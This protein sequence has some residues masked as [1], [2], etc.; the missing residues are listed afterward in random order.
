M[1]MEIPSIKLANNFEVVEI[2]E[3]LP[4]KCRDIEVGMYLSVVYTLDPKSLSLT[5]YNDAL[6]EVLV[7]DSVTEYYATELLC[8]C[9]LLDEIEDFTKY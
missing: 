2:L 9:L 6:E 1:S 4:V 3:K 8:K 5:F 7:F